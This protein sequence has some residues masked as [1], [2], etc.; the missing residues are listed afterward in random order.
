VALPYN[1]WSTPRWRQA[2]AELGLRAE[3]WETTLGL[4]PPPASWLFDRE[5]HLLCR[6][7]AT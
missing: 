5:L 6:L 3:V 4:Y 1:Y 2:L 7:S